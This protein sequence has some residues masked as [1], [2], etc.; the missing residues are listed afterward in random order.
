MSRLL[1]LATILFGAG[2]AVATCPPAVRKIIDP[3]PVVQVVAVPS[4]GSSYSPSD[5]TLRRIL[6]TLERIEAKLDGQALRNVTFESVVAAKCASCHTKAKPSGQLILVA[7]DGK[8]APL[9]VEQKKMI[10]LLVETTDTKISMP[11]NGKLT[12]AEKQ[13]ILS[14]LGQ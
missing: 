5:D 9:S 1:S 3:Q 7:E 10:K 11:K 6:E 13:A 8:P 12:D 4:Y 14:G 2:L